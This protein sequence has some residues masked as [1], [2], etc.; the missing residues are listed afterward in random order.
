MDN[1]NLYKK[2][3]DTKSGWYTHICR[4]IKHGDLLMDKTTLMRDP[5]RA[6]WCKK[7]SVYHV[8]RD[9]RMTAQVRAVYEPAAWTRGRELR[10]RGVS[11]DDLLD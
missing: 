2:T 8:G 10:M 1:S 3:C 7:H 9:R 11:I 6:Y 4:A 5:E